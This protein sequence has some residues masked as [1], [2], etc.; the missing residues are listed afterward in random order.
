M[1][2]APRASNQKFVL[3]IA[4]SWREREAVP[5]IQSRAPFLEG[6]TPFGRSPDEA[7]MAHLLAIVGTSRISA[8]AE[9]RSRGRGG[10]SHATPIPASVPAFSRTGL[11]RRQLAGHAPPA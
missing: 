6:F 3:P 7:L 11:S 9:P 2:D 4:R 8:V 10:G 1:Q 5:A